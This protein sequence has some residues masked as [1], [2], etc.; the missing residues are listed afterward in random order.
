M[1]YLWQNHYQI[2]SIIFLKGFLELNVKC[3][4]CRIKYKYRECFLEYVN[5][6][7]DLIEY[8]CLCCSKSCLRKF[9]EKLNQRFFSTYKFSS[10][11]NNKFILLLRKG[12]YPYEYID[13]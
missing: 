2:L 11:I 3:K 13:D 6:K 4:T 8:K 1:Q 12:I 7:D 10:D 5:F 9:D